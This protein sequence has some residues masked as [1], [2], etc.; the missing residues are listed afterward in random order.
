[1]N[2]IREEVERLL[3]MSFVWFDFDQYSPVVCWIYISVSKDVDPTY[4]GFPWGWQ[5]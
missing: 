4:A 5:R 3:M 1:M 2:W